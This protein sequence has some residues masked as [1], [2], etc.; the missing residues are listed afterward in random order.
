MT[1]SVIARLLQYF[2]W[3]LERLTPEGWRPG[4][5]LSAWPSSSQSPTCSPPSLGSSKPRLI[6]LRPSE[7]GRERERLLCAP[8]AEILQATVWSAAGPCRNTWLSPAEPGSAALAAQSPLQE[9]AVIPS[10]AR[11]AVDVPPN[12]LQ[13]IY[14]YIYMYIYVLASARKRG[15]FLFKICRWTRVNLAN[16]ITRNV[17]YK[18]TD[19][20]QLWTNTCIFKRSVKSL[21]CCIRL[22][23]IFNINPVCQR[24]VNPRHSR[25]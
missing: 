16:L 5:L 4:A 14:I 24:L 9:S 25:F 7:R 10:P 15:L 21:P 3:Q 6:L 19:T 20:W 18:A 17:H 23:L 22:I 1:V 12:P 2:A 13:H 11:R 8:V